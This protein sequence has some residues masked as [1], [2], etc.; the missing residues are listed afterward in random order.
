MR[1]WMGGKRLVELYANFHEIVS[2]LLGGVV[3]HWIMPKRGGG[4][5][6]KKGGILIQENPQPTNN[7]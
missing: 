2:N 1:R 6:D 7:Q 3:S 5:N 4:E